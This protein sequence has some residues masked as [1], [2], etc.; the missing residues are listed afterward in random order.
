[1]SEAIRLGSLMVDTRTERLGVVMAK[2]GGVCQ[3]RPPRGGREWDVPPKAL[4]PATAEDRRQA[5][6]RQST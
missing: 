1:M 5:T 3:L 6:T 2:E 4:R